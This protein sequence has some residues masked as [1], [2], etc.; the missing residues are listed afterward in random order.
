MLQQSVVSANWSRRTLLAS[1][2]TAGLAGLTGC[3]DST[4]SARGATDIV[5][6]NEADARRT[7]TVT[8]TPNGSDS[9]TVDTSTRLGPNADETINNE[10][11][12]GDDYTV[13]VTIADES[14]GASG[15]SETYEWRDA[16]SPLHVLV[17]DQIVFAIQVG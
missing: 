8:V 11:L 9:P 6:H 4:A 2:G 12:M 14:V 7:V 5:L 16:G 3:L 13:S 10:V 17:D 15:Y 1:F